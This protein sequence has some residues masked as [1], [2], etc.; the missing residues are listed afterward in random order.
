MTS[1][2]LDYLTDDPK[3]IALC[4]RYW[5]LDE[6]DNFVGK[7]SDIA[8]EFNL[9]SNGLS[10]QIREYCIAYS[11]QSLCDECGIGK[12]FKSRSNYSERRYSRNK[13]FCSSCLEKRAYE[14]LEI[15]RLDDEKKR[16]IIR[17]EYNLDN[18]Q[19]INIE[20]L[21]LENAVFLLSLVRLGATESFEYIFPL[22]VVDTL[23][24]PTE[25]LTFEIIRQLYHSKLIYVHPDSASTAF[26]FKN[27]DIEHFYLNYVT[28]AL[29][30]V[31]GT[32]DNKSAVAKL[33]TIFRL[34]QWEEN[35]YDQAESLWKKVAIEEC[36][37]YLNSRIEEHNLTFNP[38]EKTYLLFENLLEDY[39]VSQ[40][41]SFIWRAVKDAAAFYMRGGVSKQHAANTV[42]GKI[43][44]SLDRARAEG[45]V[46]NHYRRDWSNPQS[47]V[48]QVLY[49]AVLQ[50]GDDGFN[51]S[52]SI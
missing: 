2:I 16:Q 19:T 34:M 33:E 45:W 41:Y 40:A 47:M 11:T 48:S 23:L 13:W 14:E 8:K 12:I 18:R 20:D 25:K 36:L 35:W 4:Q 7:V 42:I 44:G 9:S 46:I 27:D 17:K 31:E 5:E 32:N 1:L 49:N 6:E 26:S 28:W 24:A 10:K 29:P 38:G 30:R 37:Q 3:L 51:K 15:K 39:S 22:K 43:Q 21:S 52:P 50:I